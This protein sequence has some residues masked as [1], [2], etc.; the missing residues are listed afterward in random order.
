LNRLVELFQSLLA[1][2]ANARRGLN[3][4]RRFRCRSV[5]RRAGG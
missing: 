1:P 4:N 5:K 3:T 2:G